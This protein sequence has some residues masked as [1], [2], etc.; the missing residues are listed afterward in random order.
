[1]EKKSPDVPY[2]AQPTAVI[3]TSERS[4]GARAF[5]EALSKAGF[6]VSF[7]TLETIAAKQPEAHLYLDRSLPPYD[8]PTHA[9]T[10]RWWNRPDRVWE[11]WSKTSTS[12]VASK[13]KIAHPRTILF[14]PL[15]GTALDPDSEY[16][17]EQERAINILEYFGGRVVV[18]PDRGMLGAGVTLVDSVDSLIEAM[19]RLRYGVVQEFLPEAATTVRVV[20]TSNEII[21][22]YSRIADTSVEGWGRVTDNATKTPR[23]VSASE[24]A[25]QLA[26]SAVRKLGLDMAGVDIVETQAGPIFLE[27]NPS[28]GVVSL[29][30]LFPDALDRVVSSLS[31]P[32]CLCGDNMP[33]DASMCY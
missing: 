13:T 24:P 10:G 25:G 5:Q 21:A 12:L 8:L 3:T 17:S 27:A 29:L 16:V 6:T 32:R 18:K 7:A 28:F 14:E 23:T 31:A 22:A 26:M 19:S 9:W 15:G 4:V 2:M 1:M 11:A 20:C 30:S 33:H